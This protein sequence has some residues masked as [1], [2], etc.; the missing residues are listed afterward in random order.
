MRPLATAL[1]IL[2]TT[3]CRSTDKLLLDTAGIETDT[4]LI[5]A[6]GDG[7]DTTEDCDDNNTLVNPGSVELCDGVDNNCDGTIDEDVTTT[8]YAD[9]DGD[10]FGNASESTE[11]CEPPSGYVS[12]GNDC[13]DTDENAY[14]SASERCDG[15]DNDC[16]GEIDEDVLYEWY[17]DA[18][19]DS[20]GDPDSAYE[21][22][23]PPPGYVDNAS[24]CDDT[25]DSSFPGGEEVCDEADNDCDTLVDEDVTTTYYQ[26]TDG[27]AFGVSDETTEACS[28]PTG[29][30]ASAGDC[31]DTDSAISPN[32][33]EL[34]DSVDNDCDG[35]ID[36][37]DAADAAT[38]YADDDG[39]SYGDPADTAT[40]CTAPS[41]YVSDDS[42]CDDIDS[43]INPAASE[44]CDSVDNDC[45][46]T[47]D[48]D[49][50][51]DAA[52]WYADNDSDG[53]GGTA[54]TVACTQPTGFADN[55]D[56]CDDGE[57]LANPGEAEVCDS[58]DN[59]CDG[60]IDEDTTTSYYLDYDGDGYGDTDRSTEAC[61]APSGYVSD[62]TDCDDSE[63]TSNPGESEVCDEIDNDCDGDIDEGLSSDYYLDY[64]GDGYGDA[65]R[66]IES[67]AAPSGYV[68]DNTDCDDT[69]TAANPGES[70]V[71]DGI[72]NDCDG[73]ADGEDASDAQEWYADDDLDGY[74]DATDVVISC[75]Q[76][77]GTV[78]DDTDCDDS[79]A[80][81]APGNVELY[82]ESDNDCDGDT[83][84]EL[85]KGTGIDGA[86]TVT[87]T[88]DLHA[89]AS[90]SRSEPDA[91]SYVVSA[92]VGD[93]VTVT[94]DADGLAAGDEVLLVNLHG[95]DSAHAAAGIHEYASVGSV[96][97]D[98]VTL[99]LDVAEVYGET[100]NSDL[101]DQS[102]VLQRV[103]HYTDV[104]ISAGALLTGT[105]WDGERYGIVAF[106]ATGTVT[107]ADGGAV[108]AEEL[109]YWGG[110]TGTGNNYDAFQGESYAG[111][112]GGDYYAGP[113][114]E[115][116][117]AY[118]A[119]Y[120]GGGANVTGGGGDYGG[121]A[122]DG[123]S[124]NGGGY[125]APSAGSTYGSADL[126]GLYFG[127]GGGGVWN[128]GTDTT[129]EDPGPGGDG[130]GIIVIGADE[131]V[132]GGAEAIS[133]AGGTT[134]HWASGTW[135]YGAGG[136]SGG[137]VYLI[138]DDMTLAVD[139][140][141]AV[142]GYGQASYTRAGGDGGGGRIR[143]DFD[144]LNT[145]S[146]GSTVA[147]AELIRTCEPD[148]GYDSTP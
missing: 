52:T 6:D 148:P 10:G 105:P 78:S 96:S 127:S 72:D 89:D 36:E 22:C 138:A 14:P 147:D 71:C 51:T 9:T 56:D 28:P 143:I 41:G 74:G 75:E 86:L 27:D 63:A 39:D 81:S 98:E 32:A 48:E 130:G 11:A 124:W 77:S 95:S 115:A 85:Y 37:D 62:D 18:D 80:L 35:T 21:V 110:E 24:D 4:S 146:Q 44:V 106:R 1:A 16:D 88:T 13:D 8:F 29:Y 60:S 40:A 46:G 112:G 97:G 38:F 50:A 137:S 87:G 114:N 69:T 141:T 122:T 54:S 108:S 128:G 15:V 132:V 25:D 100:S 118:A 68:S 73:T 70:E 136:G 144:T 111:A 113:Y 126:S 123:D 101:S 65:D 57:A 53:Y 33:T 99:L 107:I 109:G 129:G 82:D 83:D 59:D 134:T 31:D 42:D 145:N 140:I 92:I 5:D 58:I 103:P 43:A 66:S 142:G 45:D 61:A 116:N 90:G 23:D 139:G 20:Y 55:P 133:A 34:C 17:A 120:G 2:L 131:V 79:S 125:T 119:N 91:A 7:Y 12:V 135:T 47:T 26:D 84:E 67:C 117:G 64:D 104:D 30:A 102:V 93:T 49:D 94:E 3:G 19:S 76:P 121:G